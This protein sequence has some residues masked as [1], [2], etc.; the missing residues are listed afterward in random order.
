[1]CL[2]YGT[3]P[4]SLWKY[5]PVRGRT[6]LTSLSIN[7]THINKSRHRRLYLIWD[8]WLCGERLPQP[9]GN[10]VETSASFPL[11]GCPPAHI[12][13]CPQS[14]TSVLN[15]PVLLR[16]T[17]EHPARLAGDHVEVWDPRSQVNTGALSFPLTRT[18]SS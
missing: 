3:F 17:T 2:E 6:G 4:V 13:L 5:M 8:K 10:L 18:I 9:E 11:P 14:F 7:K 15:S 1:M 16:F 12:P